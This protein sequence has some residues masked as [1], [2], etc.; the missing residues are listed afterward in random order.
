MK[1]IIDIEEKGATEMGVLGKIEGQT[2]RDHISNVTIRHRLKM[3][4]IT[5]KM[6]EVQWK[7]LGHHQ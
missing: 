1:N 4:S 7:L 2:R 5:V 6:F 3:E